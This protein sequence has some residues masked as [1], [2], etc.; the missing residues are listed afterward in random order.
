MGSRFFVMALALLLASA[1]VAAATEP[2]EREWRFEVFLE[3]K[4]IGEQVFRLREEGGRARLLTEASFDVKVLFFTAYTNRHRNEEIWKDGCL[5]R[6]ESTTDDNGAP[7]RLHGRVAGE[8]FVVETEKFSTTLPSCVRSFAYWNVDYLMRAPKL[9]NS[10]TGE[11]ET[12][13]VRSLGEERLDVRG[14]PRPTRRY[15]LEGPKLR[16]D[17]WYSLDNDWL[18][19]ESASKGG[20]RLRYVRAS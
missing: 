9:L 8:G 16:I 15:A 6:I 20:R 13:T 19:L 14:A 2:R 1:G 5:E 4:P 11:Y 7:F 3:D 12:V 17:L 18:A 10:Q